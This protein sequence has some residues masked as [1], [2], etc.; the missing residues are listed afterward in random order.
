MKRIKS[1]LLYFPMVII[2]TYYGIVFSTPG[3]SDTIPFAS[4]IIGMILVGFPM[5]AFSV[6]NIAMMIINVTSSDKKIRT[7]TLICGMISPVLSFLWL[8]IISSFTVYVLT[9]VYA[10]FSVVFGIILLI[11]NNKG[12]TE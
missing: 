1:F 2:G 12:N 8:L 9:G 3:D 11:L 5:L 10:V 7:F 6:F 4:M